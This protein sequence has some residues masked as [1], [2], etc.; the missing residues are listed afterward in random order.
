MGERLTPD[1]FN[2]LFNRFRYEAFRLEVQPSYAAD[3]EREAF[4]EFLRGEPRP[5]DQWDWFASWLTEIRKATSQGRQI[6]RV[7]IVDEPPTDYQRFEL[8]MARWN[9]DAGETLSYLDRSTAKRIG[10]PVVDDWWLFDRRQLAV[11]RFSPTGI[12]QGGEIIDD[13]R[14]VHRHRI[15]RDLAVR[16]SSPTPE[17]ATA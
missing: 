17:R 1:D 4:E 5:G 7:R 11:M 12:P 10:L 13:S 14:L 6:I 15:W 9:V 2:H 8:Y 3:Y 16:H